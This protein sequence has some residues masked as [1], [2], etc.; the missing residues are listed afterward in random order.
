M[1]AKNK[2]LKHEQEKEKKK[3]AQTHQNTGKKNTHTQTHT[4]NTHIYTLF[5]TPKDTTQQNEKEGR[6]GREERIK[7]WREAHFK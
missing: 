1:T 7:I 2:T 6:G 3:R 4:Q 5:I